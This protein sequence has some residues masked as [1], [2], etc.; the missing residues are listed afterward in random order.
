MTDFPSRAIRLTSLLTWVVVGA[1]VFAKHA[2]Q[3]NVFTD[4]CAWVWM[5]GFATGILASVFSWRRGA[6][7]RRVVL[8]L[9]AAATVSILFVNRWWPSHLGGL[10]LVFVAWEAAQV[11]SLRNAAL[12]AG[13]Q[14]LIFAL[15]M[16]PFPG[17]HPRFDIPLPVWLSNTLVLGGLEAFA[18]LVAHLMRREAAT[19]ELLVHASRAEERLRIARELHDV[20]GHHLS[21][22]SL[23]LEVA[24]LELRKPQ[25]PE[26]APPARRMSPR[27]A[28][29][30]IEKAQA[31]TRTMLAQVRE[32]VSRMR[33]DE[34][35]DLA[36]A[37]RELVAPIP[38]P[39]IHLRLPESL[40]P[41]DGARAITMLRC[42]QECV[43]NAIRHSSAENLWIELDASGEGLGLRVRDDGTGAPGLAEGHGLSGMRE[44][45][46]ALSG[47]LRVNPG[48]PGF[49]AEVWVP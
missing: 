20:I 6:E 19:R 25:P 43:T 36:A 24:G 22:L 17:N 30:P 49:E 13:A 34:A 5:V 4:H 28:I 16:V 41:V 33:S 7:H 27:D 3:R 42:A 23:N 11:L 2:S 37:L 9:L 10:P 18:V 44:R 8:G 39:R 47:R 29:L 35:T 1:S 26:A 12:W 15:L 48:P 40:P 38:S 14:T 46:A 21:A 32:V 31:L 45:L